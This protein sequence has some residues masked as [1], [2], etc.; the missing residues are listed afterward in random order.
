[1]FENILM[2]CLQNIVQYMQYSLWADVRR[3]FLFILLLMGS[4]LT[5][6]EFFTYYM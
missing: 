5:C 6:I 4:F 1:M 2:K 3:V